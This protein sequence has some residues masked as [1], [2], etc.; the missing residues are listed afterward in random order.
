MPED[1]IRP[2]EV[3]FGRDLGSR[4][5]HN[6]EE[7]FFWNIAANFIMGMAILQDRKGFN[8]TNLAFQTYL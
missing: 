6:G 8:F 7:I 2:W 5:C 4:G 3:A 1:V